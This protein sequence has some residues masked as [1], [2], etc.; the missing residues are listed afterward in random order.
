MR[1]LFLALLLLPSLARAQWEITPVPFADPVQAAVLPVELGAETTDSARVLLTLPAKTIIER[2]YFV[3]DETI[4]GLDSMRL[5][6]R[7][8]Q[9]DLGTAEVFFDGKPPGDMWAFSPLAT[10]GEVSD[11][12]TLII[13][14][15]GE[16]VGAFRIFIFW[17][18][19]Y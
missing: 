11:E 5:T 3:V 12:L 7:N 2:V 10:T 14:T 4:V 18:H 16:P 9:V 19:L 1:L 8:A 17:R 13:H 15:A 6:L